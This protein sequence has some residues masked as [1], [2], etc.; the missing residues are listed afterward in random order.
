MRKDKIKK[1][2]VKRLPLLFPGKLVL[3]RLHVYL[4]FWVKHLN[5]NN[6][7]DY[8][9]LVRLIFIF[10]IFCI[11][12]LL[13]TSIDLFRGKAQVREQE[14]EKYPSQLSRVMKVRFFL[15]CFFYKHLFIRFSLVQKLMLN[16]HV[17]LLMVNI[18]LLVH[19]MEL[20]KY[21]ILQPEKFVKI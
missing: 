9:H 1:N 20:L 11:V 8:Y 13:G 2:V 15:T 14:E 4:L 16:V 10:C 21:G 18:L 17:F 6:I 3:Y 19:L 5:G 12:F 7:K